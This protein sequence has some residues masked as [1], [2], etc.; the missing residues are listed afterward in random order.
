M[1]KI[2]LILFVIIATVSCKKDEEVFGP[3][4]LTGTKWATEDNE[5]SVEFKS[6]IEVLYIWTDHWGGMTDE[7]EN[8]GLYSVDGNNITLDFGNDYNVKGVYE[9]STIT[10]VDDGETFTVK[11]Q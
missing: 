3:E 9:G 8:E 5:T 1:K 2:A 11:K 4:M 7:V 10:F 6:K